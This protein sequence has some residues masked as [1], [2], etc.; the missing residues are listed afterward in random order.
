MPER[1]ERCDA[2]SV[3]DDWDTA[4]DAYAEGQATGHDYYR[5][6]FFGPAQVA[7]CG[8]VQGLRLLDVG[9]G[10]GYFAR[11]MARRGAVVTA[12]DSSPGMRARLTTR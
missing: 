10:T 4:S 5:L 8:E 9:C 6:E 3:R 7:L 1:S 12:V 11:E 2:V